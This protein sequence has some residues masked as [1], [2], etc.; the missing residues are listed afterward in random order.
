MEKK[1]YSAP[2]MEVVH[3]EVEDIVCLTNSANRG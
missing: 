1:Q 3:F 2:E